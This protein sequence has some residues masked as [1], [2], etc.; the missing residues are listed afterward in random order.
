MF[1]A[2]CR[3]LSGTT[4]CLKLQMTLALFPTTLLSCCYLVIS[5][6]IIF[7]V[8]PELGANLAKH[9]SSR[10]D[11]QAVGVPDEGHPIFVELVY[12]SRHGADRSA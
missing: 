4:D 7:H 9:L 10:N 8:G 11:T 12:L 6:P 1:L 3:L 5:W 2:S